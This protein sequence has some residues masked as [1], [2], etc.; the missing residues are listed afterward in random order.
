MDDTY[1]TSEEVASL[2][3]VSRRTLARWRQEGK[4]PAFF[5]VGRRFL[6]RKQ[7]ISDWTES[8]VQQWTQPCP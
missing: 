5:K 7:D 3:H 4:G 8:E 6:Y 2:M 1:L